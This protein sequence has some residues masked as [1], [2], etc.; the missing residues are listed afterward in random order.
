MKLDRIMAV[1]FKKDPLRR[2]APRTEEEPSIEEEYE[3]VHEE[4]ILKRHGHLDL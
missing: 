3:Q 2:K 1:F 4:D